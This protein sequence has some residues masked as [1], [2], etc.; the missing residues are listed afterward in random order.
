MTPGSAM[1]LL[2]RLESLTYVRSGTFRGRL[3]HS[4]PH[5]G[6]LPFGIR[7]PRSRCFEIH[8]YAFQSRIHA[9]VF[10]RIRLLASCAA[11]A[12]LL[13][14]AAIASNL[15]GSRATANP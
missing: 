6:R 1:A 7:A 12:P 14:L 2:V 11:I 9:G 5:S 4:R 13:L 15:I 8:I 10:M 3:L